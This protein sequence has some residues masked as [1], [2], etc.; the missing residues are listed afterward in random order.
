M[1]FLATFV[2]WVTVDSN[3]CSNVGNRMQC[4]TRK[5]SNFLFL[6]FCVEATNCNPSREQHNWIHESY[7]NFMFIN[8]AGWRHSNNDNVKYPKNENGYIHLCKCDGILSK[9]VSRMYS[10]SFVMKSKILTNFRHKRFI[11]QCFHFRINF[12]IECLH[13]LA[14]TIS[15]PFVYDCILY[16]FVYLCVRDLFSYDFR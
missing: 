8:S 10:S 7:I 11:K 14:A 3:S 13:L 5:F 16:I 12:Y 6:F 2:I 1:W 9:K 4:Y 15:Y